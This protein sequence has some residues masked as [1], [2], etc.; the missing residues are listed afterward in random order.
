MS[1]NN[2]V[3]SVFGD[4][5]YSYTRAAALDDGVLVDVS[6]TAQEAGILYPV[7]ITAAAWADCVQWSETDSEERKVHQDQ[8]GRL[9]DV[10][11]MMRAAI[12]ANRD[13]SSL[14]FSVYRVARSG[15]LR[16]PQLAWLQADV[17]PGDDGEPV[18]TIM[19]PNED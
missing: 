9:W 16:T 8:N 1:H 7:A 18:I 19:L 14:P 5:I 3:H 13:A 10:L 6:E 2:Q 11:W 17:G 4:V 12:I 15:T